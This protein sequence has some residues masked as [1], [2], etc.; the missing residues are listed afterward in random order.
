[1]QIQFPWQYIPDPKSG[2]PVALGSMYFGLPD[3]DPEVLANQIQV[4]VRQEDGVLIQ[5][6]QPIDLDAGGVPTYLGSP[7]IID[8]I[9]GE[10]SWKVLNS[11]GGQVYYNENNIPLI[12]TGANIADN[13]ISSDK[14]ISLDGDKIDDGT[15]TEDKLAFDIPDENG[16]APYS[17]GI[18]QGWNFLAVPP[19]TPVTQPQD[20]NLNPSKLGFMLLDGATS[21]VV[22]FENVYERLINPQFA[23][24]TTRTLNLAA[25]LSG[26]ATCHWMP[27]AGDV[28]VAG[29][30][31]AFVF[32]YDWATPWQADTAVYSGNSFDH[33]IQTGGRCDSLCLNQDFTKMWIAADMV[34]YE[35]TFGVQGNVSSAVFT[36]SLDLNAFL[37]APSFQPLGIGVGGVVSWYRC[38]GGILMGDNGRFFSVVTKSI[39]SPPWNAPLL[40]S[41]ANVQPLAQ[42][43]YT[44]VLDTPFD[45]TSAV[46]KQQQDGTPWITSLAGA[47]IANIFNTVPNSTYPPML[48]GGNIPYN[49]VAPW[50]DRRGI[51]GFDSYD[52]FG[53]SDV[54]WSTDNSVWF[55]GIFTF[56]NS[57]E[58]IL[59]AL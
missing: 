14:I 17:G 8:I 29:G 49:T 59:D 23:S 41:E 39:T 30:N 48:L 38:D 35:Y 20:I 10:F 4:S 51:G 45:I 22:E 1:M 31:S 11:L 42:E 15:I 18:L 50:A 13:S 46:F 28:S 6:S 5:V 12:I 27:R 3:L 52:G 53:S 33:S 21:K 54:R 47:T 37:P 40:N 55:Q 58:N 24:A 56:L 25:E 2:R 16:V 44:F 34:I 57:P 32:Q 43:A 19:T 26:V 36:S 9:E 7:V